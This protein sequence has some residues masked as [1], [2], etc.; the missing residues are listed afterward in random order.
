[1]VKMVADM[2][3]DRRGAAAIEYGLMAAAIAVV[4]VA[5]VSSVGTAL[6]TA[7]MTIVNDF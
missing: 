1:M 6:V 7:F 4:I 3:T 2:L 5:A